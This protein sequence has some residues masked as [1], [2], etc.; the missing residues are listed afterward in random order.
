MVQQYEVEAW[1]GSDHGLTSEQITQLVD[2]GAEILTRY[3]DP[4]DQA[5]RDAALTIAYRLLVEDPQVVMAD[6]AAEVSQVITAKSRAYAAARQFV[7]SRVPGT[8]SEAGF[9][10]TV[11]VDRQSVRSWLGKPRR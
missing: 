4:D 9:A 5:E 6:L 10:R 7:V 8:V 3:P 1:L 2:A 11:G